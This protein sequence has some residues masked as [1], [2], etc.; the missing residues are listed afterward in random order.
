MVQH[1]SWKQLNPDDGGRKHRSHTKHDR[2]NRSIAK[3]CTYYIAD[4]EEY[5]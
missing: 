2:F 3:A 5:H 4:T 1:G